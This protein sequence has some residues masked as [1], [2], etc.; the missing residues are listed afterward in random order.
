MKLFVL[1]LKRNNY[2]T[3]KVKII[4]ETVDQYIYLFGDSCKGLWSDTESTPPWEYR[5]QQ[6]V[7]GGVNGKKSWLHQPPLKRNRENTMATLEVTCSMVLTA[8]ILTAPIA[9]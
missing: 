6:R 3:P 2:L 4:T 8:K 9:R 1:F 7:V 5:Q